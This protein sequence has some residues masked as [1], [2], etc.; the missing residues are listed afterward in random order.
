[1]AKKHET[2][3]SAL[4]YYQQHYDGF[5][6]LKTVRIL[7]GRADVFCKQLKIQ[8]VVRPNTIFGDVLLYPIEVLTELSLKLDEEFMR[9]QK[10]LEILSMPPSWFVSDGFPD[11]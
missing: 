2:Y 8:T 7:D 9:K 10:K 5:Y 1:M 3:I 11:A 6:S 4:D